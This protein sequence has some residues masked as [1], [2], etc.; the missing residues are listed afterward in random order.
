MVLHLIRG[1]SG[2]MSIESSFLF[3]SATWKCEMLSNGNLGFS[4]TNKIFFPFPSFLFLEFCQNA[5]KKK[6]VF[7]YNES[8]QNNA[9][10]G[11]HQDDRY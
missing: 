2:C 8:S 7:K 6:N 11:A 9:L 3:E 10:R 5:S 1:V 4:R